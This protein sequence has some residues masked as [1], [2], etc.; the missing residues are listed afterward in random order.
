MNRQYNP[1]ADPQPY[2]RWIHQ[3]TGT[4][5]AVLS[6]VLNVTSADGDNDGKWYVRY[7]NVLGEEFVREREE[8]L[9]GRFK[10]V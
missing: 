4:L 9:D 7:R 3:K 1:P 6:I 2:T 8:F 10:Q 5:Y